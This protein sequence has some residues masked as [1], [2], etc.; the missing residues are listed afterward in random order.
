[1]KFPLR[2]CD[3]R[4]ALPALFLLVALATGRGQPPPDQLE[5]FVTSAT[6][7][8]SAPQTVG[9]AVDVFSSADLARRQITSV[10]QAL[11][12]VAGAPLFASGA[13]GAS[14]SIFLRGANSNQTL[15]LVDGLR[16]NDPNTDYNVFLGG[17]GLGACDSLE[18][19]HG[20]QSTLYGGEAAGGV[21]TLR[22]RAGTGAPTP[23][24]WR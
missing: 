12:G 22:A 6:R 19:A 7:T 1:M 24:R 18:V 3:A 2:S 4:R 5:P 13:P 8:A 9:S 14:T 11:G 20:P 17:A 10:A 21:I 16:F 23:P 15:F